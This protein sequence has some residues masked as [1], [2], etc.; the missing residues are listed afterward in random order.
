[1][2]GL[3]VMLTIPQEI[4]STP[5]YSYSSIDN[6]PYALLIGIHAGILLEFMKFTKLNFDFISFFLT[7]MKRNLV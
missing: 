6:S 2:Y 1:M 7:E 3:V 4:K 5:K